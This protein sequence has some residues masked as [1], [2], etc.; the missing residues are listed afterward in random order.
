MSLLRYQEREAGLDPR[1][2]S[3]HRPET[4]QFLNITNSLQPKS[5]ETCRGALV[6]DQWV[7]TAA[8]CFY[9]AEDRSLWRVNVGKAGA[10]PG[11]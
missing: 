8:H 3:R 10:S 5:H 4:L 2:E 11:F 9:N 7:L 6:S 1:G